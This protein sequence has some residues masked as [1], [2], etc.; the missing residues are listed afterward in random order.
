[1]SALGRPAAV[2][3][4]PQISAEALYA[5]TSLLNVFGPG[6][7]GD[8]ERGTKAEWGALNNRD[9]LRLEELADKILIVRQLG[10][11]RCGT[12]ERASAGRVYVERAF[13]LRALD[14]AR[15]VE[16]RNAEIPPFLEHSVVPGDEFLRP[17]ERL[18][19]R[20]LCHGGRIRRR[21]RLDHRHRS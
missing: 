9:T 13:R 11:G 19:C 20:P 18:D 3:I 17:V 1:M 10:A 7:I 8:A 21:L 14:T 5:P 4:S 6:R 15:L 16:H 2:L 12:P